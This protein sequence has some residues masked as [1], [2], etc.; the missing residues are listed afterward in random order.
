MPFNV[1]CALASPHGAGIGRS[2]MTERNIANSVHIRR[3]IIRPANDSLLDVLSDLQE[4]SRVT[5]DPTAHKM[6]A[7]ETNVPVL[8]TERLVTLSVELPRGPSGDRAQFRAL[9]IDHYAFDQG[10]VQV[11]IASGLRCLRA[12]LQSRHVP[13]GMLF[14]HAPRFMKDDRY[15]IPAARQIFFRFRPSSGVRLLTS[16]AWRFSEMDQMHDSRVDFLY[17]LP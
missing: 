6:L 17:R 16:L 14:C 9:D 11:S 5:I 4:N 1:I 3:W 8:Q 13:R 2:M 10:Y 7:D 12:R 15:D